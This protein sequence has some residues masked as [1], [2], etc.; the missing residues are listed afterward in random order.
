MSVN[1]A[2]Y[3]FR[4]L[5]LSVIWHLDLRGVPVI[6]DVTKWCTRTHFPLSSSSLKLFPLSLTI[7][8]NPLHHLSGCHDLSGH[9]H[10]FPLLSTHEGH[11]PCL[12][13]RATVRFNHHYGNH[14]EEVHPLPLYP[15]SPSYSGF[16]D[17]CLPCSLL[18]LSFDFF[19]RTSPSL[20]LSENHSHYH[21]SPS[22]FHFCN[23]C[24]EVIHLLLYNFFF[25]LY[26]WVALLC[27]IFMLQC[28]L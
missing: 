5:R 20:F 23:H 21:A 28:T 25:L 13:H 3:P 7:S 1:N 2:Y 9:H 8:P 10:H 18:I 27:C 14:N 26:V 16:L 6:K 12:L 19:F 15:T 4:W 24:E 11:C 22:L 17:C